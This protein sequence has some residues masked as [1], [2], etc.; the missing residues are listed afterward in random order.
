MIETETT[1][2]N[3][4]HYECLESDEGCAGCVSCPDCMTD[5]GCRCCTQG[6]FMT[7]Y[8]V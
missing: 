5:A 7:C 2:C 1:E 3:C 4:R 8:D 6:C